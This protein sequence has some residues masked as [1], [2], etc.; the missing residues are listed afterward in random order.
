MKNIFIII[1]PVWLVIFIIL[2]IIG[3][4]ITVYILFKKGYKFD[5]YND[6]IWLRITMITL[7]V[8]SGGFIAYIIL[9]LSG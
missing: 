4:C 1:G 9:R 7:A 8:L 2:A 5:Y 3:A 6:P